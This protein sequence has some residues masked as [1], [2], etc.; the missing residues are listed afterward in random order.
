MEKRRTLAGPGQKCL[1][2]WRRAGID[3]SSVG[4]EKWQ[5]DLGKCSSLGGMI[6]FGYN[7]RQIHHGLP[8]RLQ[9]TFSLLRRV[10]ECECE[11]EGVY[12]EKEEE[13]REARLITDT[14]PLT[15]QG[16]QR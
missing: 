14:L 6:L 16:P 11:C 15:N 4:E 7:G 1:S 12:Q 2:R 9:E 13:E 3:V 5:F 8:Q 10:C